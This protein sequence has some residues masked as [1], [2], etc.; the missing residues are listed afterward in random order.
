MY[1]DN[2]F[3]REHSKAD[4]WRKMSL[5]CLKNLIQFFFVDA[6]ESNW[7][8]CPQILLIVEYCIQ[9]EVEIAGTP[10]KVFESEVINAI[11]SALT[12]HTN[13]RKFI[14]YL[15]REL[16]ENKISIDSISKCEVENQNTAS[17][18]K[19]YAAE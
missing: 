14:N 17:E 5:K 13:S 12:A 10:E 4:R 3:Y 16:F 11:F 2:L 8:N 1:L 7:I 9:K 19:S 6:G 15:F 18:R